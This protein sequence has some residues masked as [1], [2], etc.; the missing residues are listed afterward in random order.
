MNQMQRV[1]PSNVAKCA[2]AFLV[3][4]GMAG[5]ALSAVLCSAGFCSHGCSMTG[6]AA[7]PR[8]AEPAAIP[9]VPKTCCD[10]ADMGTPSGSADLLQGLPANTD[11]KCQISSGLPV[12]AGIASDL[13]ATPTIVAVLPEIGGDEAAGPIA[14]QTERILFFADASPPAAAWHP[15]FG[16]APPSA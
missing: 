10:K 9:Q 1:R 3:L 2:L 8:S 4:W 6:P 15:D 16:R 14:R 5:S 13:L 7:L 11:C 12:M